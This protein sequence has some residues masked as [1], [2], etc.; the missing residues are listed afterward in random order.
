MEP[1]AFFFF[2]I[3]MEPLQLLTELRLFVQWALDDY[4]MF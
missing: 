4:S 1:T 3:L 2:H